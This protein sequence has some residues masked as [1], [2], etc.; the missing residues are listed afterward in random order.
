MKHPTEEYL[1]LV[2]DLARFS[3]DD[4]PVSNEDDALSVEQLELIAAAG[5]PKAFQPDYEAFLRKIKK[6]ET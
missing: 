2:A 5:N 3:G 4:V 1:S 6:S